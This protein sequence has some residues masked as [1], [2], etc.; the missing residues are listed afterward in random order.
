M[1]LISTLGRTEQSASGAGWAILLVMA[2]LGGGMVP[3]FVMP[4][5]MAT[6]SNVS[7]VKW[8]ILALEGALWRGFTRRRDGAALRDPRRRGRPLPSR[9]ESGLPDHPEARDYDAAV[10]LIR[11]RPSAP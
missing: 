6:A 8:A 9:W 10:R 5:W 4:A 3:L 11:P 2:M 1:M 7:P